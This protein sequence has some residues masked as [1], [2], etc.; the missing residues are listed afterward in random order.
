MFAWLRRFL[1]RR[2]EAVDGITYAEL[3]ERAERLAKAAGLRNADEAFRQLDAGLLEGTLLEA[4]LKMLRFLQEAPKD[5][6][7][8]PTA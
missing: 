4:E 1:E 2:P 7:L 8:T 3:M 6:E 5:R